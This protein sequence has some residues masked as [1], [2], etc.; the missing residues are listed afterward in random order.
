LGDGGDP[1]SQPY[2]TDVG[3][4]FLN[5]HGSGTQRE[6]VWNDSNLGDLWAGGGGVSQVWSMPS[7]QSTYLSPGSY[8]PCGFSSCRAVPDIALNADLDKSP[9]VVYICQNNPSCGVN[10]WNGWGGTSGAAPLMAGYTA[11]LNEYSIE[12]G[13][14]RL[15]FANPYLYSESQADGFLFRDIT[16]GNNSISGGSTWSAQTGYDVASQT[17][18]RTPSRAR[19]SRDRLGGSRPAA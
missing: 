4:T 11:D 16:I 12:N 5:L 13:G 2:V 8:L 19:A 15:G 7:Y 18:T 17:T 6:E 10:G 1:G 14:T 9:F 3:G